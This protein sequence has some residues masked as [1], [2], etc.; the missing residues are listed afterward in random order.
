MGRLTVGSNSINGSIYTTSYKT[1]QTTSEPS[2]IRDRPD[3]FCR[4][5]VVLVRD[6]PLRQNDKSRDDLV[7]AL[8]QHGTVSAVALSL[9]SNVPEDDFSSDDDSLLQ[10][11]FPLSKAK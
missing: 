7:R 6:F 10:P 9:S 3:N 4:E 8:R 2:S 1:S 5:E 11:S